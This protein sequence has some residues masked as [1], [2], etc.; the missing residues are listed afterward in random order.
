MKKLI[1]LMLCLIMVMSLVACGGNEA[2]GETGNTPVQPEV[3]TPTDEKPELTETVG[4]IAPEET[5]A[6]APQETTASFD[7]SWTGNAFEMLLPKP[8]FDDWTTE[9]K[10]P[11]V[12]EM[13]RT[14]SAD[15][16]D[17]SAWEGQRDTFYAYVNGL[18]DYGFTVEEE[19][20]RSCTQVSVY[21]ASEDRFTFTDYG[22]DFAIVITTKTPKEQTE[23]TEPTE[24]TKQ[25]PNFNLPDAEWESESEETPNGKTWYGFH[26]KQIEQGA[27]EDYVEQLKSAG[28]TVY[29]TENGDKLTYWSLM[30]PE[31]EACVD[32][33]YRS[34]GRCDIYI[35]Q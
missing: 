8:P 23:V 3:A 7:T 5:E 27:V 18:A 4:A 32:I 30:H 31:T 34:S 25:E 19:F 12:Y 14:N 9:M 16:E 20:C 33:H 21:N 10:S 28:Y 26:T 22:S 6:A 24:P 13:W 15:W 1:T 2:A 29:E 17:E 11:Y 35:E